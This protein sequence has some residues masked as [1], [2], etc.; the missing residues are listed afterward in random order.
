M[1][2]THVGMVRR[3]SRPRP[4]RYCPMCGR[5]IAVHAGGLYRHNLTPGVP[6]PATASLITPGGSPDSLWR[7][8]P[9]RYVHTVRVQGDLL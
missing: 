7:R 3:M 4:R 6:C 9:H 2:P 8:Y 5:R 1:L